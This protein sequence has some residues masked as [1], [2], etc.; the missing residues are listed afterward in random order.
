[1]L[2]SA[3]AICAFTRR[4]SRRNRMS[5]SLTRSPSLKRNLDDLAIDACLDGDVGERLDGA[6]RRQNDGHVCRDHGCRR[7]GSGGSAPLAFALLGDGLGSLGRW[8]AG[9]RQNG[10]QI[11]KADA[12]GCAGHI[13]SQPPR[14]HVLDRHPAPY[15]P[16]PPGPRSRGRPSPRYSRAWRRF[17]RG[18]LRC[19]PSKPPLSTK[20]AL[21]TISVLIATRGPKAPDGR[22]PASGHRGQPA[23]IT[24]RRGA[25]T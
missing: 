7:D 15:R 4:S 13:Q 25:E 11:R 5:F 8:R 10:Q 3:C 19:K 6:R 16:E 12:N 23:S 9:V 24:E 20:R 1:M 14:F 17:A 22:P 18:S 21:R 2:A